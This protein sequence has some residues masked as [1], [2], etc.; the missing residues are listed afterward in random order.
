LVRSVV[1]RALLSPISTAR[2]PLVT[3]T[4]S[5]SPSATPLSSAAIMTIGASSR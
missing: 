4:S 1:A 3:G 5:P 2:Q